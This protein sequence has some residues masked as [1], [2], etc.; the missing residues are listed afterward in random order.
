MGHKTQDEDKKTNTAQ[1]TK[2]DEQR[3]HH[4]NTGVNPDADSE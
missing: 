1:K 3:I 4:Q 2:K